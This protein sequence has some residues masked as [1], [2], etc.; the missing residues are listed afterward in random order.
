M[1]RSFYIILV[2]IF[3]NINGISQVVEKG[4]TLLDTKDKNVINGTTYA[5]IIGISNYAQKSLNLNAAAKDAQLFSDFLIK[6]KRVQS[7]NLQLLLNENAT[8]NKIN[9]ALIQFSKKEFKKGDEVLIYFSGHGDIQK[10]VDK[11][12]I[13]YLLCHDVNTQRVYA[14]TNGTV[15]FD[16]LNSIIDKIAN[17]KVKINLLLDACHSGFTVNEEGAQ[18]LSES[19]LVSF[20]NT[21]R[22][23]S[24]GPSQKSYE[25]EKLGQGYFTYFLINGLLGGADVDP[26]DNNVNVDEINRY[27]RNK[28]K[29]ISNQRQ[30]PRIFALD[31]DQIVYNINPD[32]KDSILSKKSPLELTQFLS[33]KNAESLKQNEFVDFTENESQLVL[34]FNRQ[35][36][37]TLLDSAILTFKEL[38]NSSLK[39]LLI[40]QIKLLLI[41]ALEVS[42]QKAVNIILLGKNNLPRNTYFFEAATTCK[43]ILSLLDSTDYGYKIYKLYSLYLEAYSYI[44]A[45]D[46]KNYNYAKSLLIQAIQLEKNAAY[47]LHALGLVE[48]YQYNFKNAEDYYRKAIKLIPTWT[49]PRSSLGN[50]LKEQGKYIEA[51]KVFN[52]VIKLAPNFSWPY[53][54]IANVYL[55]LKNYNTAEQ[56]YNKSISIDSVDVCTEFNNLGVLAENRGNIKLA[57]KYYNKS[58]QKDTSYIF[59]MNNM[60]NLYKEIDEKKAENYF[61]HSLNIEPHFS[62]TYHKYA[63]YYRS[64]TSIENLNKAKDLYDSAIQKNPYNMWAYAGK[65][66]LLM[67]LKDTATALQQFE[68]AIEIFPESEEAY[69]YYG[70]YF[71]AINNYNKAIKY[72]NKSISLNPYY[73]WAYQNLHIIYLKQYKTQDAIR[74]LQM[75]LQYFK[76][77]PEVYNK[78][79]NFYFSKKDFTKALFYYDEAIKTDKN[80]SF[81]YAN[82]AYTLLEMNKYKE[83]INAFQFA[84]TNNSIGFKQEDFIDVYLNN[85]NISNQNTVALKYLTQLKALNNNSNQIQYLIAKQNYLLQNSTTAI[86]QINKLL[87]NE[88]SNILKTTYYE[89][90]GWCYIDLKDYK[91]AFNCFTMANNLNANENQLGIMV[92]NF[93]QNKNFDLKMYDKELNFLIHETINSLNKDYSKNTIQLFNKIK[94]LK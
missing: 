63:D 84:N 2:C 91:K 24:C 34:A 73:F 11:P 32:L 57:E 20:R 59:A 70:N 53:N 47:I 82:K 38:K 61:I 85:I 13:G 5:L 29:E 42:P 15:T 83:A 50:A 43:K 52:E 90:L 1:M 23:L 81:A 64:S 26:Q 76:Q 4:V 46:Y 9:T 7:N 80:Y 37:E 69:Y 30:T 79:G 56:Y 22:Y 92:S 36:K 12:Y 67:K 66:W 33:T 16:F 58:I 78:L 41:E 89:L 74:V 6:T 19:A 68:K 51:L 62:E 18:L 72:Y 54:N 10:E 21:I 86:E 35:L 14:G 39:T 60:A 27:V 71:K 25:D 75:A 87:N 31:L 65:A 17:Q 8:S 44:R 48:E 49:Y 77:S 40:S 93:L 88:T 55:S 3:Y 28:V 45:K 94:M